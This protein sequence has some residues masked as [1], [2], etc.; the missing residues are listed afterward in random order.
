ML[1]QNKEHLKNNHGVACWD[2]RAKT[3]KGR[4]RRKNRQKNEACEKEMD[5]ADKD[6]GDDVGSPCAVR[7]D[8]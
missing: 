7:P 6:E 2:G 3:P 4:W 5:S 1:S 8:V